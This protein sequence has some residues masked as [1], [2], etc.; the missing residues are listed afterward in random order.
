MRRAR[1]EQPP[2]QQ[3]Q[4]QQQKERRAAENLIGAA[5][6]EMID[7]DLRRRQQDQHA[8]AGRG[9]DHGHRGRQPRAEPAAEQD[10]IRNVADERNAEADAKAEAELELPELLRMGGDQERAAEQQQPERI[11]GARPRTV[12]QPAD[13]RRGQAARQ[14]CQRIDRDDL[15]AVPAETLRDR[16]QENRKTLAE[17]AADHRQRKTQRQH[18]QRHARRLRAASSASPPAAYSDPCGQGARFRRSAQAPKT[19]APMQA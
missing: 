7:Q 9:I 4:R 3:Q 6:A 18:V 5:P 17:T 16:L 8:G 19:N 2:R 11:D 10:R 1:R 15:R 13:Q 12:E 14:R